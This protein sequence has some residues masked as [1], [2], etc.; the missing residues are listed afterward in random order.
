MSFKIAMNQPYT[1]PYIGYFQLVNAVDKF[2]AYD[3]V[4]FIK[5]GW[6]NRN[7]ILVNGT[8]SM[9]SIPLD[10]ASSSKLIRETAV[11]P[12]LYPNWRNK[13]YKTLEFNYKRAPHYEQ[14]LQILKEI[15]DGDHKLISEIAIDSLKSVCSFLEISTEI[16]EVEFRYGNTSLK[17]E[18]RIIDMCR[19]E[20]ANIYINA[21]GGQTLYS[22][23]TFRKNGID[24]KFLEPKEITYRQM[25][26]P[27]VPWLSIIDVLM[28]NSKVETRSMLDDY[29]LI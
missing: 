26:K 13:F 23:E 20:N 10:Q 4:T 25:G 7:R 29:R 9:F 2:I 24:L 5:N 14:V 15:L 28:F 17:G 3:H 6:V 21:I 19:S 22:R 8:P 11:N 1:F 12:T 16:V 27:F 18:N